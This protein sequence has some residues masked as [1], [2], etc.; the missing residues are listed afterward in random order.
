MTRK[1]FS[2]CWGS[3][4]SVPVR[5][6][7]RSTGPRAP[8][9]PIERCLWHRAARLRS[10]PVR[11][12]QTSTGRL[13][14]VPDALTAVPA[15]ENAGVNHHPGFKKHLLVLAASTLFVVL[16]Y[17]LF[18][19]CA[20]RGTAPDRADCFADHLII[21]RGSFTIALIVDCTI[22]TDSELA[23]SLY[24]VNI[25]TKEQNSQPYF[26]FCR[27]IIC[28]TFSLLYRRLAFS[29]PSVVITNMVCSG[30]SSGRAYL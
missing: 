28:F 5:A 16:V 23:C 10:T 26:A 24:C 29:I 13:A 19:V 17:T 1:R 18:P 12:K 27:S 22:C 6:K 4:H 2:A 9:I 20:Q 8:P 3:L 14:P 21:Q 7:P 30:T 11:A 25:G 15:K